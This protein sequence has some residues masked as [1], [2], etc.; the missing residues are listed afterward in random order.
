M[1]SYIGLTQSVQVRADSPVHG[2]CCGWGG[3][4]CPH[5]LTQS[6]IRTFRGVCVVV[7]FSNI[8]LESDQR[9]RVRLLYEAGTEEV[10]RG[11]A[12]PGWDAAVSPRAGT[13]PRRRAPGVVRGRGCCRAAQNCPRFSNQS[14]LCK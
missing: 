1:F 10:R 11:A 7:V 8:A 2:E 4:S 13:A 12:V 9:L 3:L 6:P 14:A 5:P